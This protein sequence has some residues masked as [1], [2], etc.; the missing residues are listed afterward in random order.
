MPWNAQSLSK[1]IEK[2]VH[3]SLAEAQGVFVVTG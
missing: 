1:L 3:L 2:N